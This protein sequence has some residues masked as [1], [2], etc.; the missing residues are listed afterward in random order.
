LLSP[1][2]SSCPPPPGLPPATGEKRLAAREGAGRLEMRDGTRVLFLKGSPA[3]MGPQHG[4]LLKK[5]IRW[6]ANA[7]SKNVASHTRFT[8][9]DLKEL[10]EP[11]GTA[12]AR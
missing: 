3:E 10:P 6:V 2:R 4:K 11:Q 8:H 9:Y 5:E 12:E 1:L 7:D